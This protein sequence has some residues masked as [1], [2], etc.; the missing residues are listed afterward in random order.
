MRLAIIITILLAA[1][2][3]AVAAPSGCP[4]Q[5]GNPLTQV[6]VYDGPFEDNVVLVPDSNK[7]NSAIWY[8]SGIYDEKR[9]VN[10]ECQ[11]KNGK[12]EK[13]SLPNRVKTCEF[14]SG[15]KDGARF[16]CT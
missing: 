12:V 15:N 14:V 1:T 7:K 3:A 13:L 11:Y 6:S 9:I 8:V 2:N 5:P 4:P 16:T 10:V